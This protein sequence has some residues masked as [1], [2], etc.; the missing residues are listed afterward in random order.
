[1]PA[2]LEVW[3]L[4]LRVTNASTD[5]LALTWRYKKSNLSGNIRFR[6][7]LYEGSYVLVFIVLH[8]TYNDIGNENFDD[9]PPIAKK[10]QTVSLN[11]S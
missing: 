10:V 1:M 2:D 8:L 4:C 5:K 3:Y 11:R 6:F 9:S 7:L